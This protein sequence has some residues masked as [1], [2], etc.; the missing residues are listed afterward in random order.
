MAGG[1]PKM[2]DNPSLRLYNEACKHK[3]DLWKTLYT[4][5]L[6][7]FSQWILSTTCDGSHAL[8]DLPID[9]EPVIAR[10]LFR[11]IL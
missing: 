9:R 3:R 2:N 11:K 6:T 8:I 7:I 1:P 5:P 10:F 4:G